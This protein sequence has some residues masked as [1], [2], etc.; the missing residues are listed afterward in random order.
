MHWDFIVV[1][2]CISLMV[3][4]GHLLMCLFVICISLLIIYL[5]KLFTHLKKWVVFWLNCKNSTYNLDSFFSIYTLAKV[6]SQ[7]E[8][9]PSFFIIISFEEQHFNFDHIQFIILSHS[10]WFLCV[11]FRITKIFSMFSRIFVILITFR[12][13]V[14]FEL[15]FV[16][17]IIA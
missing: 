9:Y 11:L 8:V 6:Y 2:M 7:S 17:Q 13:M 1:L 3:N 15:S 10:L 5:F 12:S 4:I 14:H 16:L